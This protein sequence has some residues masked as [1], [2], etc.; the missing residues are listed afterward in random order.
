MRQKVECSTNDTGCRAKNLFFFIPLPPYH[1]SEKQ[2]NYSCDFTESV[3]EGFLRFVLK[4]SYQ[5]CFCLSSDSP[6]TTE[7]KKERKDENSR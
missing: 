5:I 3:S 2:S 6:K 7:A 1:L 4:I